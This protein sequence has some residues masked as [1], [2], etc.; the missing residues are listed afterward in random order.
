MEIFLL[1]FFFFNEVVPFREIGWNFRISFPLPHGLF[2]FCRLVEGYRLISN[3]FNDDTQNKVL[4]SIKKKLNEQFQERTKNSNF[5]VNIFQLNF[6][7]MKYD[8][9]SK[10]K[11]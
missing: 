1:F 2:T 9:N 4:F 3:G 10:L 11:Y 8:I 5:V 7:K 6:S